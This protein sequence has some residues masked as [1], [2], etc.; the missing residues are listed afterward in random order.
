MARAYLDTTTDSAKEPPLP[1]PLLHG[2]EEKE[3]ARL[4]TGGRY[5]RL[6]GLTQ[7][8]VRYKKKPDL[9]VRFL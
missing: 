3:F 9:A 7:K 8:G 2:M 4:V 5:A 1:G 6:H